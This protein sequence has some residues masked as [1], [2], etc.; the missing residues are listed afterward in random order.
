[1]ILSSSGLLCFFS[2]WASGNLG[3]LIV[4]VLRAWRIKPTEKSA[5]HKKTSLAN[6]HFYTKAREMSVNNELTDEQLRAIYAWIDGI[7][8]SRPKRNIARDFSDGV[9]L[10][11]VVSAYFPHLV[12]LHNYTAAS[13]LKHKMY[14]LETLNARVLKRLGYV[15]PRSLIED[16]AN[17]KAGAVEQV[18][19]KL[20]FKMAKYRERKFTDE[21]SPHGHRQDDSVPETNPRQGNVQQK[22]AGG[23]NVRITI[24]Q[25]ILLEKEQQIR[26]L[27]E[28]V[29]ILELKV[30]KLEQLVRLKDQ[31]LQRLMSGNMK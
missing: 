24:D 29:E 18:L 12:E 3:I 15:L 7:P 2:F 22:N 21:G 13:S 28:N 17:C 27:Q 30:A 16:V 19:N 4:L 25:N 31:K 23:G 26:D 6:V 8:L 11:E 1:M 9:L 20:Q 14:N 5:Q 10:A